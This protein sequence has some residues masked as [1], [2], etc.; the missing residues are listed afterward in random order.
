ML[1]LRTTKS[2]NGARWGGFLGR[3]ALRGGRQAEPAL[4][5]RFLG[6]GLLAFPQEMSGYESA[7]VFFEENN[8][9]GFTPIFA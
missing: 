8:D 6:E 3:E 5:K 1:L 9:S 2:S 7:L 4:P